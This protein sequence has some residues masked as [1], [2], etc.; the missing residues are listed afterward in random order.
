M[1]AGHLPADLRAGGR[2]EVTDEI[3]LAPIRVRLAALPDLGD[4]LTGWGKA[5]HDA[6][7]DFTD[8]APTDLAALIAEVEK[9]TYLLG[10]HADGHRCT[11]EM[12]SPGNHISPPDWQRDPW[13]M[14]HPDMDYIKAETSSLRERADAA[15]AV[16]CFKQGLIEDI[17]A[18]CAKGRAS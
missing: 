15:E 17:S 3:D 8:N 7:E 14:T 12:L 13:C 11:C 18:D 9:L 1:Q 16:V 4:R 5:D 2:C 6:W 10:S